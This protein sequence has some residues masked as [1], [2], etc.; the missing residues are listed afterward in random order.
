MSDLKPSEADIICTKSIL[1]ACKFLD[2][3]LTDHMIVKSFPGG[4]GRSFYSMREKG[5]LGDLEREIDKEFD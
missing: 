5:E 3:D 4:K 1:R 2:M